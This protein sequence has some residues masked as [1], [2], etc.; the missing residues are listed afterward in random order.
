MGQEAVGGALRPLLL[1]V[2]L[3]FLTPGLAVHDGAARIHTRLRLGGRHRHEPGKSGAQSHGHGDHDHRSERQQLADALDASDKRLKL[4]AQTGEDELH[5]CKA[6]LKAVGPRLN[7]HGGFSLDDLKKALND[8]GCGIYTRTNQ[9]P[10]LSDTVLFDRVIE[11]E[12]DAPIAGSQLPEYALEN[13][14]FH[15]PKLLS[16]RKR[17]ASK[18]LV[19]PGI[20]PSNQVEDRVNRIGVTR[21]VLPELL[22]GEDLY[23]E[24]IEKEGESSGA[25]LPVDDT[26]GKNAYGAKR[27][28]SA[29]NALPSLEAGHNLPAKEWSTPGH[30]WLA[31]T[32]RPLQ[33]ELDANA[34]K[35]QVPTETAGLIPGYGPIKPVGAAGQC[36]N[37]LIRINT[38]D[39]GLVGTWEVHMPEFLKRIES[40]IAASPLGQTADYNSPDA[41]R[42]KGLKGYWA[43]MCGKV[44]RQ[45]MAL[46][47][48]DPASIMWIPQE[49]ARL[50]NLR[51]AVRTL[52]ATCMMEGDA[53]RTL[54]AW[55]Y[56]RFCNPA[57]WA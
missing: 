13:L 30:R 12:E 37:K 10:M 25:I 49:A 1:L 17:I 46:G 34:A 23:M 55:A 24:E 53:G 57:K 36:M 33:R 31:M 54:Y 56:N 20:L 4:F 45:G 7:A 15:S 44:H 22:S 42:L 2:L 19:K 40:L 26:I 3:A 35:G 41:G 14:G 27:T 39:Q 28:A 48:P 16:N 6:V 21:Y 9:S 50:Q 18:M 32:R 38:E 43:Y 8:E 11:I 5:V 51:L 52:Y 29:E 47:W